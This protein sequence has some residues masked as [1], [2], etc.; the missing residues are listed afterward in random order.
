MAVCGVSVELEYVL[1]AN[2]GAHLVTAA[3]FVLFV[4]SHRSVALHS[5]LC[6]I[7]YV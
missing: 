2:F 3:E 7:V 6:L 4:T 1:F 5:V